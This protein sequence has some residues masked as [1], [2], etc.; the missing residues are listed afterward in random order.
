M[1]LSRVHFLLP[2]EVLQARHWSFFLVHPLSSGECGDAVTVRTPGSLG[3]REKKIT[4]K[5]M[6]TPTVPN[7]RWSS[8]ISGLVW[9]MKRKHVEGMLRQ[10][11]VA[12]YG[13]GAFFPELGL[14]VGQ[15]AFY[16]AHRPPHKKRV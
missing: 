8:R 15:L 9:N 7:E 10:A 5:M 3:G 14:T 4:K 16:L 11:L 12:G 6:H 2:A 13:T 1:T